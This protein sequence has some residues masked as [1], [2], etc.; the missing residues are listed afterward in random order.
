MDRKLL[1]KRAAVN[2]IPAMGKTEIYTTLPENLAKPLRVDDGLVDAVIAFNYKSDGAPIV[3]ESGDFIQSEDFFNGI[4]GQDGKSV[5]KSDLLSTPHTMGLWS[6]Y[7]SCLVVG[8]DDELYK[9]KGVAFGKIPKFDR[10]HTRIIGGQMES[11]ACWEKEYSN[12]FNKVLKENNIAPA[13]EY[14]GIYKF[15][16]TFEGEWAVASIIKAKGDTRFDELLFLLE[17]MLKDGT[18]NFRLNTSDADSYI[19]LASD[20]CH[21]IGKITGRLKN[22]MDKNNLCWSENPKYSNAH[23]GNIMLYQEKNKLGVG[24]VDFDASTSI[25][26]MGKS[27]L[28]KLQQMEL[29]TL[30]ASASTTGISFRHFLTTPEGIFKNYPFIKTARESFCKGFIKGYYMDGKITNLIDAGMLEELFSLLPEPQRR[31]IG[32]GLEDIMNRYE[33]RNK[34]SGL[35]EKNTYKDCGL[36]DYMNRYKK[37]SNLLEDVLKKRDIYSNYINSYK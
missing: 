14:S 28:K 3:R 35:S 25:R 19:T 34:Y 20:L 33:S 6:G 2:L 31:I 36:S 12:E 30:I 11:N 18:D 26:E 5:G 15:P 29:K 7:R 17:I 21:S 37:K 1:I 27:K 24:L 23:I 10:K 22:L 8:S 16:F 9:L 13:M 32:I 4:L